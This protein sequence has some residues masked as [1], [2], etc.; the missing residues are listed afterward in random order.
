[1]LLP[2][3]DPTPV[4]VVQDPGAADPQGPLDA[5][6][7]VPRTTAPTAESLDQFS[8]EATRLVAAQGIV[9]E[10]LETSGYTSELKLARYRESM[11]RLVRRTARSLDPRYSSLGEH[12]TFLED[13]QVKQAAYN[14]VMDA[15]GRIL[16]S[17]DESD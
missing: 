14:G 1:M 2:L 9:R 4:A 8:A 11:I 12:S 6:V 5:P 17:D 15:L 3:L 10:S 13:D 7:V 16:R